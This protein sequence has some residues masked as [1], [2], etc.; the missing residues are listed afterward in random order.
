MMAVLTS[1]IDD[2]ITGDASA[3]PDFSVDTLK[4]GLVFTE[5]VT[6]TQRFTVRNHNNKGISI[7]DIHLTGE[8]ASFFRLNVDGMSGTQFSDVEIRA[9]D[10]IYVMVE[11]TLP[12]NNIDAPV[13][14][15]AAISFTT[16][17]VTQKVIV[18][19]V[20]QDVERLHAVTI[21]QD[22]QFSG[23][24]PYQ[25]FDSLVVAE[26]R[27]LSLPAGATLYF[28]DGATMIVRGTLITQGSPDNFVNFA[29]D[30]TGDVIAG[31]TFDLMSKQWNG[32]QF[33]PSSKD[34]LLSHTN[35]RNTVYGVIVSGGENDTNTEKLTLLNCRLRNSGDLV[36]E[37]HNANVSA[38]GCEFAEAANGLVLLD[39]GTYTFN[40]CTFANNY[41]FSAIGGAAVQFDK[42]SEDGL[43]RGDL[44]TRADISNSIIYGLGKDVSHGDLTGCQV[45]LRCCVLKST[46]SND[47]NFM[48]CLWDTDPLFYTVREDYVFDY[49]LKDGSPAIYAGNPELM[50]QIAMFDMYGTR[51][52]A[53]PS[54]GAY[55]YV[56]K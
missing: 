1:C 12:A 19:A 43:G 24:K 15:D 52:A 39:G 25:V 56:I 38:I 44:L 23:T 31:I 51:R 4:L 29:G 47:D 34:N 30:R 18:N 11:A 40:H 20:G 6:T 54:L 3:Q 28:H 9:N 46:G 50:Q 2:A 14:V 13:S 22:T 10:S 55:E 33:T 53:T 8:N 41:L 36:L 21:D 49:R 27:T 42:L 45:F 35:I 7:S 32:L 37:S 16:N 5:D 26:G 48:N 17:T